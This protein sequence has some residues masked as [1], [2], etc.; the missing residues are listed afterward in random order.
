MHI[1]AHHRHRIRARRRPRRDQ[2]RHRRRRHRDRGVVPPRQQL[3]P[4]SRLQHRDLVQPGLRAGRHRGQHPPQPHRDGLHGVVIEQVS[5]GDHHP[6]QPGR[7]AIGTGHLRHGDIQVEPGLGQPGGYRG[8]GDPG[9]ARFPGRCGTGVLQGE[10]DLE[11]RVAGQRPVRRQHLHQPLERDV[12]MLHRAQPRVPDPA[13]QLLGRRVPGQVGAQ[14]QGVD[15]EPDQLIQRLISTPSDRRADRD[16]GARA[17]AGQQHRQR[18]LDHHE[19]RHAL[20]TGQRR[21][22]RMHRRRAPPAAR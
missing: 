5:G 12:L 17:E 11:Q 20:P 4:F 9:Q 18:R 7:A 1:P 19:H 16:I 3:D 21:Q 15:E 22:P 6:P 10:R 2:L 8:G 13:Q 14:H